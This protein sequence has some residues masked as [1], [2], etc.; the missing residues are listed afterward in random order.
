MWAC[1]P[2]RSNPDEYEGVSFWRAYEQG[3]QLIVIDPRKGF[4]A[5]RADVWLQVRP[6]T[7]AAMAMGFFRVIVEEELYD[8]EFVSQYVH[9]WDGFLDRLNEYPLE[10]VE[11]ITWVDRKLIRKAAR[12]YATTKP[13]A[14]HWGGANG[15]D[16]QLYRLHTNGIGCRDCVQ[17]CPFGAMQFNEDQEVAV[18]CD[19]CVERLMDSELPACMS[20]CPTGCI[21]LS[22][23]KNIASVFEQRT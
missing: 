17:A 22:G 20:V 9:G 14:I 12:L 6:I 16:Y 3:A 4:L 23:R 8:K 21:R 7:D 10:R 13:A 15:A 11:E 18:K 2:Q 1:N 19:L 5:K